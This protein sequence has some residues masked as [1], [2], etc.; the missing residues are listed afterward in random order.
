MSNSTITGVVDRLERAG[1]VMRELDSGDRRK[2]LVRADTD[3]QEEVSRFLS[4]SLKGYD[5]IV[6]DYS[7]RDLK[8]VADFLATT[9]QFMHAAIG[10]VRAS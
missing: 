9:T 4:H 8:L 7:D 6:A 1:F 3:K 5:Q 10:I 2:V